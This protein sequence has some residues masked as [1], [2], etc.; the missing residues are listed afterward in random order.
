MPDLHVNRALTKNDRVIFTSLTTA[1]ESVLAT[2]AALNKLGLP[3]FQ[4][5]PLH[6][7]LRVLS[8]DSTL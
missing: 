2:Y 7:D 4:S 5:L 3:Y 8:A 1:E 6:G